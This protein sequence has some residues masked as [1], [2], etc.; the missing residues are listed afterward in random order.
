MLAEMLVSIAQSDRAPMT[1]DPW[2][3]MG[4]SGYQL[5]LRLWAE[6]RPLALP[7][8]IATPASPRALHR[9][10]STVSEHLCG[11]CQTH[12][13]SDGTRRSRQQFPTWEHAIIPRSPMSSRQISPRMSAAYH[14][15]CDAR[16]PNPW[17]VWN[18]PPAALSESLV[19]S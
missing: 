4:F 19:A 14:C 1:Y 5:G 17:R 7:L 12:R 15:Y 18:N 3:E 13:C 2:L 6:Q 10:P 16:P 8:G 9:I 11:D